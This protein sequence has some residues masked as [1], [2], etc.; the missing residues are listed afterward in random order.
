MPEHFDVL[1]TRVRGMNTQRC[2]DPYKPRIW[3]VVTPLLLAYM[4]AIRNHRNITIDLKARHRIIT[5]AVG[6]TTR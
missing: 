5:D 3:P 4:I 2:C 6:H 1:W